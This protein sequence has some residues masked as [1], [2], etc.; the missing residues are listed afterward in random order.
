M[1]TRNALC[2]ILFFAL[3]AGGAGR[4][5]LTA[6]RADDTRRADDVRRNGVSSVARGSLDEVKSGR[7]VALLVSKPLVVDARDPALGALEDYR[8]SLRGSPPRT[9]VAAYRLIAPKLNKYIRNKYRSATAAASLAEAD[10]VIVFRVTGQHVSV[11]TGEPFVWSKMY[12]LAVGRDR[13]A[14]VVWES[15]GDH[16]HAEKAT[17]DFR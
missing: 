6:Q 9:H 8:N 11:I 7:R 14:R 5:S 3:L 16:S 13:P 17:A 10:L 12:V 2:E 4:Q 1:I 15:E